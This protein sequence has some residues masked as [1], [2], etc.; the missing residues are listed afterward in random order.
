MKNK[1]IFYTLWLLLLSLG[2][3]VVFKNTPSVDLIMKNPTVMFNVVQRIVGLSAFTLLFVQ[4]ILGSFMTKL[5]TRFGGWIFSFHIFEGILIYGLIILHPT[6][7]VIFNYF[8][9][10]G[11]DPFYV[12]TEVCVLC[13]N[14]FELFY[15]LGRVSFWLI[16]ISVFAGL[17]RT[18][19]PW[20]RVNWKKLH[21]INFL[22]FILISIHSI[23]VGTDIGTFPFSFF[24]G[25]A[26]AIISGIIVYKLYKYFKWS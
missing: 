26:I 4:I 24:H 10:H 6:L 8:A 14:R 7:F 13:R 2:P 18:A 11:I 21:V 22:S 12:F 16:S 25:P 19:T 5:A 1:I 23:G 9:G 3:I 17:F 15:T 20:L